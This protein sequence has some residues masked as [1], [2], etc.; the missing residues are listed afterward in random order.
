MTS[1][2][3]ATTSGPGPAA[4]RLTWMLPLAASIIWLVWVVGAGQVARVVDHWAAGVTMLFGSF[5]AGSS[6]E[7]GGAVAFPVLTKGLHVPAAVARSFGLFI[8]AVGMTMA[9]VTIVLLGRPVHRRAIAVATGAAIAG[10]LAGVAIWGDPDVAFWPA[11]IGAPWI[12]ATFSVVLATTSLMMLH[13]GRQ[14]GLVSSRP[15]PWTR[16]HALFLVGVALAGGLLSSLTGTGANIV[17]FLFLV[18]LADV[19]A[20]T[21]L[22]TAIVV[23]AAVSIIGLVLFGGFDGQLDIEVADGRVVQVGGQVVDFDA[24]ESDLLGLWLA[25]VPVVVWGAPLGAWVAS[26]VKESTLIGF[27]AVLAATEVFTTFLL[28]PELRTDPALI[29]FFVGG[30]VVGP[31]VLLGLRKR[32]HQ[33]FGVVPIG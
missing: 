25:A 3:E 23:M 13:M 30:L 19:D 31:V 7:G 15:S 33:V 21:A 4:R 24:G 20:K 6:P 10:F 5:L 8:Q 16:R 32:R 1:G 26:R 11:S 12:K 28:V 18:V 9:A 17:V 14:I 2:I 29:M 27:V 22:S